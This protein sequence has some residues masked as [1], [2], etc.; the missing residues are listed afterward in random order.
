MS[1]Q[2]S[3]YKTIVDLY[4]LPDPCIFSQN[5]PKVHCGHI[6]AYKS[7]AIFV[8]MH[9]SVSVLGFN[10]C[11]LPLIL[12]SCSNSIVRLAPTAEFMASKMYRLLH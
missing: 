8:F 7:A 2:V 4:A 10:P 12:N 3:F 11:A 1:A 5:F 6:T 9:K